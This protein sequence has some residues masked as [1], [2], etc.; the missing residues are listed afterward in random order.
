MLRHIVIAAWRNMA[1]NK[2]I[3]AIAI[4]GLSVGIAAALLMALVVRN[5]TSFDHFIPGHERVYMLADAD[6]QPGYKSDCLCENN[7]YDDAAFFGSKIPEIQDSTRVFLTPSKQSFL[8]APTKLRHG[9]VEAEEAIYWAD[10]NVFDLLPLPVLHG[11]LASALQR[12]DG[13][14]LPKTMAE[15]YFGRDDVVGQ[16][17]FRER[18]SHG[19]ASSDPGLAAPGYDAAKWRVCVVTFALFRS[20]ASRPQDRHAG[21]E[22][23]THQLYRIHSLLAVQAGHQSGCGCEALLRPEYAATTKSS[24]KFSPSA[25]GSAQPF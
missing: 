13:I 9:A 8:G 17:I 21:S 12:P 3:S 10:P 18:S 7:E 22:G 19:G 6:F 4:L 24:Y 5:Q 16:I 20:L 2:L 14:V 15:K 25:T 1:A 23:A 11:D